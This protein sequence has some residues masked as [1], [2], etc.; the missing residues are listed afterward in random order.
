GY[1]KA[2]AFERCLQDARIGAA[3]AEIAGAGVLDLF[4]SRLW[5]FPQQRGHAHDEPWRAVATHQTILIDERLLN[6]SKLSVFGEAFDGGDFAFLRFDGEHGTGIDRRI[7]KENGASAAGAAIADFFGASQ[8]GMIAQS[9]E[10][11]HARLELKLERFA[12]D[13]EGY[14]NSSRPEN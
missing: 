12:V 2:G 14:G 5:I 9:F 3:T 11:S 8:V 7:V 6:G 1:G 13:L 4:G 10:Q